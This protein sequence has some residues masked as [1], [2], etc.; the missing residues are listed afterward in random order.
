MQYTC[1]RCLRRGLPL[2]AVLYTAVPTEAAADLPALGDPFG[3]GVTD[4]KLQR[5]T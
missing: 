5:S 1:N 2:L 3:A 4:K